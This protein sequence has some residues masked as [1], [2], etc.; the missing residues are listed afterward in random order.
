LRSSLNIVLNR[1][2]ESFGLEINSSSVTNAGHGVFV[3]GK[4]H[5]NEVVALYPGSYYPSPPVN[6]L[7]SSN[8]DVVTK[9][10]DLKLNFRDERNEYLISCNKLGGYIDGK[11]ALYDSNYC[12]GHL[13]NHPP[14]GVHPNVL[15]YDFSWQAV[16]NRAQS[17]M[18]I[19]RL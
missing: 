2:I 5:K 4:V 9:F 13:V 16:G 19:S 6:S 1:K 7:Y 10:N 14:K 12:I 18:Q 11:S 15:P 8:G 3:N 17:A